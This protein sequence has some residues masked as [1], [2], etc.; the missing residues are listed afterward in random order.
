MLQQ[1]V[2][3]EIYVLI[4]NKKSIKSVFVLEKSLNLLYNI[5]VTEIFTE[6]IRS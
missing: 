3:D 2:K 4:N 6:E 5:S 1:V